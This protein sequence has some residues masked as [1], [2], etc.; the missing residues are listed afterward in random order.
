MVASCA[1]LFM[2]KSQFHWM[3]CCILV[4]YVLIWSL[5]FHTNDQIL[6]EVS[7]SF[8]ASTHPQNLRQE[9]SGR[10]RGP[11]VNLKHNYDA[12]GDGIRPRSRECIGG[13]GLIRGSF[14]SP[15]S[16]HF[17]MVWMAY[18]FIYPS[19]IVLV[20]TEREREREKDKHLR[21]AKV[22]GEFLDGVELAS[23]IHY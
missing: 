17:A 7:F 3:I 10:L 1:C 11:K 4:I 18:K 23:C 9:T 21:H 16:I 14:A 6:H 12:V 13:G 2:I 15:L 22:P 8:I 20:H 19:L 5:G